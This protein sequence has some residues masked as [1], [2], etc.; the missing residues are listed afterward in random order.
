MSYEKCC[1]VLGVDINTDID[2]IKKAYRTKAKEWHPD[3][4]S[5][6]LQE[7]IDNAEKIMQVINEAYT[8]ISENYY[9]NIAQSSPSQP[10]EDQSN[11][12]TVNSEDEKQAQPAYDSVYK[13]FEAGKRYT[14]FAEKVRKHTQ[15]ETTEFTEEQVQKAEW[16]NKNIY[17][18]M[19]V[20]I[21][22]IN[23]YEILLMYMQQIYK[24]LDIRTVSTIY[25]MDMNQ[26]LYS[27][28]NEEINGIKF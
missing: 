25:A 3:M 20:G 19:V 9:G 27:G 11:T 23:I 8:T 5:T 18:N 1:Q 6:E 16:R 26:H 17:S 21:Y 14:G 15:P 13:D 10:S 22:E 24:D 7:N 4:H 2:G 28:E 12:T